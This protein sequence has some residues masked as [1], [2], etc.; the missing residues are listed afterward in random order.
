RLPRSRVTAIPT[1]AADGRGA[2]FLV[3]AGGVVAPRALL[4]GGRK[5]D[6]PVSG[7]AGSD[8]RA[9]RRAPLPGRSRPGWADADRIERAAAGLLRQHHRGG[10]PARGGR[11]LAPGA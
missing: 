11:P 9:V 5:P 10:G 2:A 8:R 7:R 6:R 3:V 1:A 4:P